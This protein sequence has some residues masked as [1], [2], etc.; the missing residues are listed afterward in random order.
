MR[1]GVIYIMLLV[2]AIAILCAGCIAEDR[3][4]A[5][6][7]DVTGTT[8]SQPLSNYD[9]SLRDV[10]VMYIPE[11]D[12]VCHIYDSVNGGGISC[13]PCHGTDRGYGWSCSVCQRR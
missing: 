5:K 13:I 1:E 7:Q 3:I 9:T 11:T 2:L 4:T 6:P 12:C 8:V 10:S